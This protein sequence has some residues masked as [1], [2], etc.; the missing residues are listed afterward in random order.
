MGVFTT[1]RSMKETKGIINFIIDVYRFR[2]DN[3][4]TSSSVLV[5]QTFMFVV[6]IESSEE[7]CIIHPTVTGASKDGWEFFDFYDVVRRESI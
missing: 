7:S 6:L 5:H 1:L 4:F 3:Y 2:C